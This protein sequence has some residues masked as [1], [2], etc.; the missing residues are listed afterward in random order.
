[1]AYPIF[2]RSSWVFLFMLTWQVSEVWQ[3]RP[4]YAATNRPTQRIILLGDSL[5]EGYGVPKDKAFPALVESQLKTDGYSGVEVINAGISGSTTAGGESRLR[6]YL[7]KN[8]EVVLLALGGNDGLRGMPV[9]ET[10][11]NLEKIIILAKKNHI[12]I[13][14]A[15]MQMPPNYGKKYTEEYKKLYFDLARIHH[16]PMVP[17]LLEGIAGN[18]EFNQEDGIHPNEYGHRKIA[19]LVTPHLEKMISKKSEKVNDPLP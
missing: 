19:E 15:G 14:L 1:M 2:G 4:G 16:L 6:W 11:R 13:L 5:T 17:F 10:K 8:P 12:K 9:D 18:R 3:S 7:K